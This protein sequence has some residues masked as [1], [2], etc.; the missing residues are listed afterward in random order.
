M[1]LD[2]THRKSSSSGRTR[3]ATFLASVNWLCV[4]IH[5]RNALFLSARK[6]LGRGLLGD[7]NQPSRLIDALPAQCFT[8]GS[9]LQEGQV[10]NSAKLGGSNR[11]NRSQAEVRAKPHE[12]AAILQKGHAAFNGIA[13][14]VTLVT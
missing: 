10:R 3:I 11:R 7:T 9:R 6:Q 8:S 13:P 4:V 5:C 12:L 14:S 1:R 2:S